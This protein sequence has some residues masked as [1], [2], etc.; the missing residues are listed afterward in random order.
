MAG[1]LAEREV[2][3]SL[4]SLEKEVLLGTILESAQGP[5]QAVTA[6]CLRLPIS[7]P[8]GQASMLAVP[9]PY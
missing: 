9:D 3:E 1:K 5:A 6:S 2:Q 8:M 4:G 7:V